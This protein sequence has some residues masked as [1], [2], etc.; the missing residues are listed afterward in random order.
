MDRNVAR[1]LRL[2]TI[3]LLRISLFTMLS[4]SVYCLPVQKIEVSALSDQ[5]LIAALAATDKENSHDAVVEIMRRG[6][7]ML[8]SLLKCKGNKK[9]FYGAGLGHRYSATL[10]PLP[11]GNAKADESRVITVE[12]A[13]LYLISAIFYDSLEFAQAPYLADGSRVKMNRFNTRARV[14]EAWRS[15]EQWYARVQ[16][17]GMRLLREKKDD[18]LRTSKVHFWG[19]SESGIPTRGRITPPPI[20]Y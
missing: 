18:P 5:E 6:E 17:A 12:V 15:V 20:R 19:T 2:T 8:P 3:A 11:T 10:I 13:A 16:T 4:A 14:S 7:R 1:L 9:Y